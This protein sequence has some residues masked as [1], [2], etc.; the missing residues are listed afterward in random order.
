MPNLLCFFIILNGLR[1]KQGHH[2][3]LNIFLYFYK[4]LTPLNADGRN[5]P[6]HSPSL[7]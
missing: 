7:T 1:S 3:S 6:L 4:I 5:T 2:K